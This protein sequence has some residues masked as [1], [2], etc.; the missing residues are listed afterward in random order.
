MARAESEDYM[1]RMIMDDRG[2]ADRG[3]ANGSHGNMYAERGI[4][5]DLPSIHASQ[6]QSPQ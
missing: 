2:S 3:S 4:E 1:V 6:M 5:S